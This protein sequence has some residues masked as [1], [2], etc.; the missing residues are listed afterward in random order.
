METTA[1][2]TEI[3]QNGSVIIPSNIH[4]KWWHAMN[5]AG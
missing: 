3:P 1:P 5:T 4:S 2:K